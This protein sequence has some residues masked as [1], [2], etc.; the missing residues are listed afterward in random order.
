MDPRTNPLLSSLVLAAVLVPAGISTS[1]PNAPAPTADDL[2]NPQVLAY[3]LAE[4]AVEESTPTPD[5]VN[6]N[7]RPARMADGELKPGQTSAPAT[8]EDINVLRLRF[9]DAD[10]EIVPALL[11]TPKDRRGPFPLVIALHGLKSN[12]AQVCGQVAPD[13]VKQGFAVLA[14]DLPWHGERPGDPTRV[15][16]QDP[17]TLFNLYKRAVTDVRQCIDLAQNRHDLDLSRGVV[18]VG[19]S[20]G[21]WIN[22]VAGPSDPRVSAMVLMVGGARETS[23]AAAFLPQLAAVDPLLA[24]PHFASRPLLLLNGTD[25][26]TVTREMADRLYAAAAEPKKQQWYE[27]GHRLPR[28]AYADA[29]EWVAKTWQS[30]KPVW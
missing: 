17:V 24:I 10:G 30:L 14:P 22:S 20:M 19:Y 2:W 15:F 28:A 5:Q 16:Q 1:A 4:V 6:F 7:T 25:D 26:Q 3:S 11:C 29:A 21:S 18:L 13:L 8:V 27:S 9:R 12:K 23:P